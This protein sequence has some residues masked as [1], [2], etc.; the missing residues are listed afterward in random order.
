MFTWEW[1]ITVPAAVTV[2]L[3]GGV[4]ACG[5][6]VKPVSGRGT[7]QLTGARRVRWPR[8]SPARVHPAGVGCDDLHPQDLR[9]SV[10]VTIRTTGNSKLNVI[11]VWRSCRDDGKPG[12]RP[13]A[14]TRLLVRAYVNQM[15][16]AVLP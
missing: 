5:Q 1:W 13:V 11:K 12:L 16:R 14:A 10:V 15:N 4:A 8:R 2:L 6:T 7:G 3:V 9:G